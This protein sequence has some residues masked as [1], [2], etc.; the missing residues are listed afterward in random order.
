MSSS[1]ISIVIGTIV[2]LA[3]GG[4]LLAQS[5]MGNLSDVE[6]T[7]RGA[8]IGQPAAPTVVSPQPPVVLPRTFLVAPARYAEMRQTLQNPTAPWQKIARDSL[9]QLAISE[10]TKGPWSVMDKNDNQ[11]APSGNKHDFVSYSEYFWQNAKG[12]WE[13]RDGQVNKAVITKDID[14]LYK[15]WTA[16]RILGTAG[17]L[18]DEPRFSERAALLLRHW[19]LDPASYMTPHLQYAAILVPGKDEGRGVG[20]HRM[21][22][23]PRVLDAVALL[24]TTPYWTKEDREGFRAWLRAYVK[25][26]TESKLGLEERTAVNNHGVYYVAHML[27]SAL[28][29]GDKPLATD[30]IENDYKKHLLSQIEPDG[31]LP[32]EY[33][34]TRPLH[35]TVYTLQGFGFLAELARNS[36]TDLYDVKGPQGQTLHQAFEALTPYLKGEKQWPAKEVKL[37]LDEALPALR[38]GALRCDNAF[39][40]TYLQSAY[41]D[42][43][44]DYQN[45]LWP[46]AVSLDSGRA[47]PAPSGQH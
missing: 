8:R 28:Y 24:E 9:R 3:S 40:E 36:G 30:L 13:W 33:K 7:N 27:A 5:P 43:A 11:I 41:P 38:L 21:K 32:A 34:R 1:R 44:K 2:S 4:W 6:N 23:L 14:G 19:F 10:M 18:L 31:A 39:L 35:Y 45:I 47:A 16:V 42:W 15:M 26:G 25:W 12:E 17:Y 22:E 29:L 37:T 20:L 46:P